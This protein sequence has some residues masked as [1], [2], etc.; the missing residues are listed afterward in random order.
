MTKPKDDAQ[1]V[2]MSHSAFTEEAVVL[3]IGNNVQR[4]QDKGWKLIGEAED[5]PTV[6]LQGGSTVDEE[7]RRGGKRS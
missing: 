4:H 7:P 5:M 2:R 3:N 1:Y 6:Q